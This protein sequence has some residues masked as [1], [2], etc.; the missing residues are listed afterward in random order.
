[1]SIVPGWHTTIFPP[2]FVAGAIL[3]GSI[4]ML[5]NEYHLGYELFRPIVFWYFINDATLT[6][7]ARATRLAE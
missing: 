1:M 4:S 7:R 6:Y 5:L 2:Y 3:T